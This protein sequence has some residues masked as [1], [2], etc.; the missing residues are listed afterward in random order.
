MAL[1]TG[2]GWR[3]RDRLDAGTRPIVLGVAL[4][5]VK[6]LISLGYIYVHRPTRALSEVLLLV[7]TSLV[8]IGMAAWQPSRRAGVVWRSLAGVWV[9]VWVGAQ[10]AQGATLF[11]PITAPIGHTLKVASAGYTLMARFRVTEGPWTQHVWYWF[12]IAMMLTYGTGIFV[13]PL[14]QGLLPVDRSLV[15]VGYF[16]N[17]VLNVAGYLLMARG[18][19]LLRSPAKEGL[20]A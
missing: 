3:Y 17:M 19:L 13:Q 2:L 6:A 18:L 10:Y 1:V 11:S 12:C 15:F 9:A 20:A 16:I 4:S 7:D 5:V 14:L 8:L